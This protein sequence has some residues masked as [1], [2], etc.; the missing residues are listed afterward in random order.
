MIHN[1]HIQEAVFEYNKEGYKKN[2]YDLKDTVLSKN[3]VIEELE[4]D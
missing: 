2:Q 3:R 4:S 1:K